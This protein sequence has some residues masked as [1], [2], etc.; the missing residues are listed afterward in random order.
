MSAPVLSHEILY[1]CSSF[2]SFEAFLR[3][4]L[5]LGKGSTAECSRLGFHHLGGELMSIDIMWDRVLATNNPPSPLSP[6]EALAWAQRV[7][8]SVSEP[9]LQTIM[10]GFAEIFPNTIVT[11]FRAVDWL[12]RQRLIMPHVAASIIEQFIL[13]SPSSSPMVV[14]TKSLP[15]MGSPVPPEPSNPT[16]DD[17]SCW[18]R[19]YHNET[20]AI[21]SLIRPQLAFPLISSQ[22]GLLIP[23][24]E[25]R[26]VEIRLPFLRLEND[27]FFRG[28]RMSV[29]AHDVNSPLGL[30]LIILGEGNEDETLVK[31]ALAENVNSSSLM[32]QF[33][34][35]RSGQSSSFPT[36][37][38][39]QNC[40][41]E[42]QF[43][44]NLM[45]TLS[46]KSSMS[47]FSVLELNKDKMC[48]FYLCPDD[49]EFYDR[50]A[51]RVVVVLFTTNLQSV[52][53]FT[54][55]PL[56]WKDARGL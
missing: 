49:L 37:A 35:A 4:G 29:S 9:P 22:E 15:P 41:K 27:S 11:V 46:P 26:R 24:S 51:S 12:V 30:G 40:A 6:A 56:Y 36:R 8:R 5:C 31:R 21:A 23:S 16:E 3:G 55:K 54:D 42:M 43:V 50:N 2:D 53:E 18:L 47:L 14:K 38:L 32:Y 33:R 28:N 44:P 34:S 20:R 1:N 17:I 39:V 48:S 7:F 25:V 13:H 45:R 10:Q 19:A 52:S